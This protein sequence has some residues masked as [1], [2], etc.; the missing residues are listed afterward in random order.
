[1]NKEKM[2]LYEK[3]KKEIDNLKQQVGFNCYKCGS[4]CRGPKNPISRLDVEYMEEKG[5]NLNGVEI[6]EIRYGVY[7]N[8]KVVD[9]C[10]YYFDSESNICTIHPNNPLLCYTYPFVVRIDNDTI[11]F[12]LC[13]KEQ[14]QR[15]S[16]I[17]N[18]L[19]NLTRD[20]YNME[21]E[22]DF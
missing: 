12:K 14:K 21:Y 8:L 4:C 3:M 11:F 2:D 6:E 1:M 17:T 5:V 18:K 10:C 9:Y 13:L 22:E 7:G 19:R 15:E 20:L 16:L